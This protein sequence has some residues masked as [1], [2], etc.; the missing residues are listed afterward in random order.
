[1]MKKKFIIIIIINTL[2]ALN[3]LLKCETQI[4]KIQI[5]VYLYKRYKRIYIF[6]LIELF[7]FK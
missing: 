2:N 7:K 1:M 4:L 5:I 3:I 6:F